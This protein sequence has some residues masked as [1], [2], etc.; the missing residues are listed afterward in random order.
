MLKF[1]LETLNRVI[2]NVTNSMNDS[3]LEDIYKCVVFN[4]TEEGVVRVGAYAYTTSTYTQVEAKEVEFSGVFM[5]DAFKLRDILATSGKS[6]MIEVDHVIINPTE[7]FIEVRIK[8]HGTGEFLSGYDKELSYQLP[9]VTKPID[10]KL[11]FDIL[12]VDLELIPI[13]RDE[14]LFLAKTLVPKLDNS[15][16]TKPSN[17][18]FFEPER[19]YCTTNTMIN[20]MKNTLFTGLDKEFSILGK[21]V[22]FLAKLLETSE[23]EL[24]I[25]YNSNNTILF[26]TENFIVS[27]NA[28]QFR[29]QKA[30]VD[31]LVNKEWESAFVVDNV[32]L[33]LSIKRAA[34]MGDKLKVNITDNEIKVESNN[35]KFK[36][37]LPLA[38][39]NKL[40]KCEFI[41]TLAT[42]DSAL[43]KKETYIIIYLKDG[44]LK[45]V[46]NTKMWTSYISYEET[47][48]I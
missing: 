36:N 27:Y 44:K 26:K 20:V 38:K 43:L 6:G 10:K 9:K 37:V 29:P 34:L 46:D 21:T 1:D 15:S 35:G 19:I 30:S 18:L 16:T 33:E 42:L 13:N 48:S 24:A 14:F 25:C 28:A 3:N 8:E 11:N 23:T 5:V 41:V 12:D 22:T 40:E 7:T 32:L 47:I 39:A 31:T 2:T 45:I 17:Y 4:V